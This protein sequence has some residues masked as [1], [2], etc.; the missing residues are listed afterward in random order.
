MKTLK[1]IQVTALMVV[2]VHFPVLTLAQGLSPDVRVVYPERRDKPHFCENDETLV[3]FGNG[4]NNSSTS[5]K[6][7]MDSLENSM[8][9]RLATSGF[10]SSFGEPRYGM[11]FAASPTEGFVGDVLS[12]LIPDINN[13]H[14]VQTARWEL[15]R[16]NLP[17]S[18]QAQ[19]EQELND[20]RAAAVA[21]SPAAIH[22]PEYNRLIDLGRPVTVASH[23][24][25]TITSNIAYEVV[26]QEDNTDA[27]AIIPAAL[28]DDR[29]AGGTRFAAN[30]SYAPFNGD[31]FN[32]RF[33]TTIDED[34]LVKLRLLGSAPFNVNNYPELVTNDP[35]HNYD[36]HYVRQG[37]PAE[38]KI[39]SDIIYLRSLLIPETCHGVGFTE[40]GVPA[41][42]VPQRP[43]GTSNYRVIDSP[44]MNAPAASSTGRLV[45]WRGRFRN[46]E[47]TRSLS[48]V[49][50]SARYNGQ[51]ILTP[52]IYRDG[53]QAYRAPGSVLGAALQEE[54]DGTEW[55]VAVVATSQNSIAVYR[56]PAF[57]PNLLGIVFDPS[58]GSS[59]KTNP[60]IDG[61]RQLATRTFSSQRVSEIY[62]PWFFN[63]DGTEGKTL[64]REDNEIFFAEQPEAPIC[65]GSSLPECQQ[66]EPFGGHAAGDFTIRGLNEYTLTVANVPGTSVS[67]SRSNLEYGDT[68]ILAVD[69]DDQYPVYLKE[70]NILPSR[71]DQGTPWLPASDFKWVDVVPTRP[72]QSDYPLA[73]SNIL[74]CSVQGPILSDRVCRGFQYLSLP[75]ETAGGITSAWRI[76][77]PAGDRA[78]DL[79][80]Q[81]ADIRTGTF[82]LGKTD[83]L[84]SASPASSE[85]DFW[86]IHKGTETPIGRSNS[87]PIT[88]G[89]GFGVSEYG[90]GMSVGNR[91]VNESGF[92]QVN[93]ILGQYQPRSG[94]TNEI[95]PLE[96]FDIAVDQK[97]HV[98]VTAK[99]PNGYFNYSS[100]GSLSALIGPSVNNMSLAPLVAR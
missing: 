44:G 47:A 59:R 6:A 11:A 43:T 26:E 36:A 50:P 46:G 89:L 94:T 19:L 95:V 99:L 69:Y 71:G 77:D 55:I 3:F 40:A 60:T 100:A 30:P 72:G 75:I 37:T 63:G 28:L 81:Y 73:S 39:T 21:N 66:G 5:A 79:H 88:F 9:R 61:W 68:G 76:E 27:F 93:P 35:G 14:A 52:Y 86:L 84:A 20:Y 7:S 57:Q 49:G 42:L 45:D 92:A 32:N 48:W 25:G 91:T 24:W 4:V 16:D 90:P 51:W 54:T 65:V 62:S 53:K 82:V 58:L 38:H 87:S 22:G 96:E 56:S 23:S 41:R 10:A 8:T 64:R 12:S 67:M 1:I 78:V 34:R 97:E 13:L 17:A 80:V 15:G 98:F 2:L 70:V 83:R 85:A 18:L 33:Y 29:V 74:D 31:I